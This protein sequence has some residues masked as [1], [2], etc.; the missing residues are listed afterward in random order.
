MNKRLFELDAIRGIAALMVVL[1]HYSFRY[2]QLYG[3]KV[4]PLFSIEH[5]NLGVQLFF[6]VSGFV[7]FMT[8]DKASHITDFV[9][10]RLSRL[11]P[12][13]WVAVVLTFIIVRVFSLPGREIRIK[14]AIQNLTMIQPWL[15]IPHVDGVYWTLAVELSFY[16]IM[17]IL[18]ATKLLPRI[19]LISWLGLIAMAVCTYLDRSQVIEIFWVLRVTRLLDFGNLFIAGIMFY[20]LMHEPRKSLYFILIFALVVEYYLHKEVVIWIAVYFGIFWAFT[21][22]YLTTFAVKPLVYLG[23]ISYSLYLIH[24]N[25]GYVIIQNLEKY[26]LATP[27]SI[28][29]V[30]GTVSILV[31][32][33]MY[34]YIEKPAM[35]FVRNKWKNGKFGNRE[36]IVPAQT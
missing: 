20:K 34:F 16:A 28:I 13:Y 29:I 15:G 21:K 25:I 19:E 22:G 33:L 17:C 3:Y 24:Q 32:S 1:Y 8:L 14:Y 2:G 27:I 7:I 6:I 5:G 10:S 9:V 4:L 12:A 23:S 35:K 26:D 31:A 18:F 36:A 30:P 11:Y